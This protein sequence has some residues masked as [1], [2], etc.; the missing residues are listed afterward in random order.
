MIITKMALPRRTFLRGMGVTLALPFLDAMVPSLSAMSKAAAKPTPRLG[1]FY[2]PNGCI[3]ESWLPKGEGTA[4]ELSPTLAALASYRDQLI[5][6]DGLASH[7]ASK[8]TGA[9]LH[10]KAQTAFLSGVFLKETEGADFLAGTT[11]DQF[12]A[13]K[14]S[15]DT[16]LRS[17]ELGTEPGFLASVCEQGI[18]CVYQN[19]MAWRNPTTPLPVENN[20]RVVFERLFGEGGTAS[21]RLVQAKKDKSILDW[22]NDDVTSLQKQ[23]GA[24]DRVT[25]DEYLSA[26]RDVEQRIQQQ[27]KQSDNSPFATAV[28]TPPIGIPESQDDHTKLLLDLQFLAYQAD[29]TR[30]VT[31]MVRR[32]E[33]QATYPQ[34][35]VPDAHHWCSHHGGNPEKI[36]MVAK[37]NAHHVSLFSHLVERMKKTPDGDG[38]LLDH[39]IF[40]YG[41]GFGD[42]NVHSPE[43]LP[44]IVVGGGCGTL[45]GGRL[46][47][48]PERT[49][50]M[51]L[52]VTL[53]EKVGVPM[54]KVG[55]S[56]GHLTDL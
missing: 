26:L 38:T 30:V 22:V 28:G 42:G 13:D 34:I 51:N 17:L 44:I 49:P 32:E 54:E 52:G 3:M 29:I 7:E 20:P 35:G 10:A 16:P 9:G 37:I 1:F 48:Y 2:V 43:L 8:G 12:A 11:I 40:M 36:A 33:S 14:L 15:G 41:A 31:Y 19:T 23:L 53:L 39:A 4:F 55:D 18:S 6:L 45:K 46:L 50:L 27:E 25:V 21:Q 24:A 5:V 56:T 47:K